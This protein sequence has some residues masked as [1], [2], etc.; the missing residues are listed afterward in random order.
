MIWV[1]PHKFEWKFREH[2]LK[3]ILPSNV[4]NWVFEGLFLPLG[5]SSL[6]KEIESMCLVLLRIKSFPPV[7][8]VQTDLKLSG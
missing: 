4:L 8:S 1:P 7:I 3:S 5:I 6:R 2:L